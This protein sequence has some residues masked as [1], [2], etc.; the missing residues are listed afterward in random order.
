MKIQKSTFFAILCAGL[1]FFCLFTACE[2]LINPEPEAAVQPTA[3]PV[4]GNYT[5][6]QAVTLTTT[7]E[8]AAI[9]YTLDGTDPTASSPL[10]SSAI[11]ISETTTLKAIAVK[12]GMTNSEILTETYT[13]ILP[14]TVT[15]DADGGTPAPVS[16]VTVDSGSTVTQPPVMTKAWHT[17]GGWY[18]DSAR[19]VPAVFPITVTADVSLYAKWIVIVSTLTSVNDARDYLTSLNSNTGDNPAS[20]IM[21]INLGTMTAADSGWRQLLDAINTTG[22]Y[23]N[24]D[25]SVCTM[26]ETSFNPDASVATGKDR[27]VS[28]VMP[29]V[30]TS[31]T[32]GSSSSPTFRNFSNLK[33]IN[34]ANITTI[35]S[36]AFYDY[37][38]T[39]QNASFPQVTSIGYSA[40]LDCTS[41]QSVSFLA[42]AQF[43]GPSNISGGYYNPFGGCTSL[44]S[45]TL[46]GTG[47]L[48]VIENGRALILNGTVL[49]AYPSASGTITMNTITSINNN[50]FAYCTKL[51]NASFPQVTTIDSM[52]FWSCSG[53]QSLNIPQITSIGSDAFSYTETT[54][55]SITMGS[56]APTLGYTIFDYIYEGLLTPA[57]KIVRIKIPTGATGYSPASSPFSGTSVTVNS[58][59][60]ENWVNGLRGGGWTGTTWATYGGGLENINHNI[61]VIIERQ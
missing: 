29:N 61:S 46:S 28:L 8:G 50:A 45:F 55:L 38:S 31:I 33:S 11:T 51:Q 35:G 22:K 23:V 27:I 14:I 56:T 58:S 52:A 47:D 7:T 16:P 30:A 18:T 42:S 24:L 39:L 12:S 17:F 44:T 49:I 13:V 60:D 41:L 59:V 3:T 40:F 4:G 32:G 19:T 43:L 25:L 9:H 37:F 1:A 48:S 20:L 21:N 57:A 53:L 5:S 10:Y 54:T 6:A 36:Y 15:F 34:G 2:Q 26:T